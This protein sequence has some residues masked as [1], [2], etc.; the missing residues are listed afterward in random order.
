MLG[1]VI[2]TEAGSTD[3]L[4]AGLAER[5]L[6]QGR[7][8]AGAV[9]I[10]RDVPGQARCAM[11]LRLLPSGATVTISQSLGP[12]AR[13]CRLDPA[14]LEYAVA[15]AETAL[16]AAPELL[17]VNKFGK[18]EIAGRGF[19]GVIGEALMRGIPVLVGLNAQ[20]LEGF[21]GFAGAFAEP[22]AP[23]AA[24]LAD[25]CACHLA[26]DREPQI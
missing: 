8:L 6:A 20:N 2:G 4:L 24:R 5:L 19:R 16:E 1:Y 15:A 10:N 18:Q 13:G 7:R 26:P 17:I 22:V 14:G 11:D 21:L 3:E 9:Q 12:L 23:D 25:W